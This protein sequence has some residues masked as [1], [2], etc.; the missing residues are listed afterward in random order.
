[1]P[2][3]NLAD[4]SLTFTLELDVSSTEGIPQATLEH[5]IKEII[6]Q[7]GARVVE[8]KAGE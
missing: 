7:I 2:L 1:M 5:K 8:E 3:S 6:R 4:G